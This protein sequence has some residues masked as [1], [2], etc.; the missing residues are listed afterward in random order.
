MAKE[1]QKNNKCEL[2]LIWHSRIMTNILF[3][4]NTDIVKGLRS[5]CQRRDGNFGKLNCIYKCIV[6]LIVEYLDSD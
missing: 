5:A 1:T 6:V 3:F 2:A 4:E